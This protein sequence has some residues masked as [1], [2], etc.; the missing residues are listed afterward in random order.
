MMSDDMIEIW[1]HIRT[2]ELEVAELR[3]EVE[4]LRHEM[5]SSNGY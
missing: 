4:L 5:F 1:S 2:L 3:K